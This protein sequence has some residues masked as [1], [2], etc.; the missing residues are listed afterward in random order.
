MLI[1]NN[2]VAMIASKQGEIELPYHLSILALFGS[3][4]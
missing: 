2:S 4:Q 1:L 3:Q